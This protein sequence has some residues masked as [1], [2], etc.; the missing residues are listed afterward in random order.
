MPNKEINQQASESIID[1]LHVSM[2]FLRENHHLQRGMNRNQGQGQILEIIK[3]YEVQNEQTITQKMLVSLLDMT[4]QSASEMIKKLESKGYIE[5]KRDPNDGRGYLVSMTVKGR[6]ESNKEGDFHPIMLDNLTD[7][8]KE[9]LTYLLNKINEDM[10]S[11]L[12]RPMR[13]RRDIT[14]RKL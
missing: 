1:F 13:R 2:Q 5:R 9:Q 4:P 10:D 8:E 3:R 11:K 12:K 7:E 14:P 6:V